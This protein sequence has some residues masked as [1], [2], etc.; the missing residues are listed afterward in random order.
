MIKILERLLGK[1]LRAH[2][3]KQL[4]PLANPKRPRTDVDFRVVEIAPSLMCC[5]AVM[6]ARGRSYLL[7]QAPRLPLMGCSMPTTCLCKFLKHGDRRDSDRRLFGAN[8]TNR[9]FAGV[10]NRKHRGRRLADGAA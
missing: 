4:T 1:D 8:E 10:E 9:W 7:R 3:A 5:T 2:S 6:H